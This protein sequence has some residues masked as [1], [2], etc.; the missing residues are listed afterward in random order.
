MDRM[1][2]RVIVEWNPPV[3]DGGITW[4]QLTA[5][6][7]SITPDIVVDFLVQW[8]DGEDYCTI[9]D[10]SELREAEACQLAES[11]SAVRL[12]VTPDKTIQSSREK[13]PT[14]SKSSTEQKKVTFNQVPSSVHTTKQSSVVGKKTCST[15]STV[16]QANYSVPTTYPFI[17]LRNLDQGES[18]QSQAAVGLISFPPPQFGMV[19]N[20]LN[21]PTTRPTLLSLARGLE[22]PPNPWMNKP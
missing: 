18:A 6:L 15:N 7:Q 10:T 14:Q 12:Y 3:K 2:R 8:F 1:I 20:Q 19:G 22:Q 16:N 13:H 9:S 5:K 11:N 17:V 4:E 21:S